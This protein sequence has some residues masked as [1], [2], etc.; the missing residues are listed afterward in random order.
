MSTWRYGSIKTC[1]ATG[2]FMGTSVTGLPQAALFF[3]LHL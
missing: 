1:R 2:Q 3:I